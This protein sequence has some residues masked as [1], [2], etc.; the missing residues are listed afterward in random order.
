MKTY[1]L[2]KDF[3]A[4]KL[5][6]SIEITDMKLPKVAYKFLK[7]IILTL[8]MKN[9]WGLEDYLE[10]NLHLKDLSLLK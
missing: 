7:Q 2:S 3:T 9:Y 10:Y 8:W 6:Q 1:V 5:V 4:T